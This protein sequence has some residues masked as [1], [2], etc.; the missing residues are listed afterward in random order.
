MVYHPSLNYFFN[1][2]LFLICLLQIFFVKRSNIFFTFNITNNVCL[3]QSIFNF[4]NKKKLLQTNL[5][6]SLSQKYVLY[7]NILTW[8]LTLN[9]VSFSFFYNKIKNCARLYINRFR[10]NCDMMCIVVFIN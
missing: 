9:L 1:S 4:F 2:N 3:W 6:H 10:F 5:K 8:S 7:F